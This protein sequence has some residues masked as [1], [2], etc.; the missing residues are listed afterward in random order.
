MLI[1]AR[2]KPTTKMLT[3]Y[4]IT[5]YII[6]YNPHWTCKMP[7]G[8]PPN[9][10]MVATN[11]PFFRLARQVDEYTA[12]DF[13]SYYETD[14]QRNWGPLLP[15]AVGHSLIEGEAKARRNLKLP[16][17]RQ[18]HGIISLSL[19]P[20][21]GVVLQTGAH[22]SHYTWWRTQSFE[23]SNLNMLSI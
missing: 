7:E 3:P 2:N 11:H 15:L 9:D 8:C 12:D 19:N 1:F 18:Y 20:S 4:K 6:V 17:F 22:R 23:M 21:D 14:P 10:V 5:D 16:M 13:K